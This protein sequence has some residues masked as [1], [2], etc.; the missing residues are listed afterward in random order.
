MAESVKVL[1][2]EIQKI[3]NVYDLENPV[4]VGI[5]DTRCAWAVFIDF[6]P[7]DALTRI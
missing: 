4:I 2:E 3:I 5:E 7:R 1:P 6:V